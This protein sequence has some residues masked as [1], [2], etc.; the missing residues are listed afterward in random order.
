MGPGTA[1][2]IASGP[3][4]IFPMAARLRDLTMSV[5]IVRA[6][7]ASHSAL[8]FVFDVTINTDFY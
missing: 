3:E 4:K 7:I 6:N 1:K 8:S 5:F 2:S